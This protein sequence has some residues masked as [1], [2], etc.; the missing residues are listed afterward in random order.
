[1][2]ALLN[3]VLWLIP[4]GILIQ[5]IRG[6]WAYR[7]CRK[8]AGDLPYEFTWTVLGGPKWR[9]LHPATGRFCHICGADAEKNESCNAGLHS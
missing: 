8:A 4:F 1:M 6:V 7:Q 2:N 9:V 5:A 3:T